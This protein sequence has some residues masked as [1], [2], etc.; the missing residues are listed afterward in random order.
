MKTRIILTTAIFAAAFISPLSA[1]EKSSQ[2][3]TSKVK[4]YTIKKCVVSDEELGSMGDTISF[5]YKGQEIKVCCKPCIKKFKKDPK[6][7]LKLLE[8]EVSK[9][10][11]T[12]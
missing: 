12:K 9:Q 11:K 7:Y 8:Q 3:K 4:P 6:K 5:A 1:R 10:K 2:A